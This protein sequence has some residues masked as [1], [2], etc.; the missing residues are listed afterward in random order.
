MLPT[1]P[2]PSPLLALALAVSAAGA[3]AL[4][5]GPPGAAAAAGLAAVA[6]L[7]LAAASAPGTADAAAW[8]ETRSVEAGP[9]P[10]AVPEPP[11]PDGG[12][13]AGPLPD[14]AVRALGEAAAALRAPLASARSELSML[15]DRLEAAGDLPAAR[16]LASAREGLAAAERHA[17]VARALAGSLGRGPHALDLGVLA[18][19]V[20]DSC[21]PAVAAN[22]TRLTVRLGCPLP[23]LGHPRALEAA[24]RVLLD[25]GLAACNAIAR[26]GRLEVRATRDGAY[27]RVEIADS[28]RTSR[29]SPGPGA[30][31]SGP[32]D[33]ARALLR[34]HGGDLLLMG[35]DPV[36]EGALRVLTV[37]LAAEQPAAARAEWGVEAA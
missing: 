21:A 7:A 32:L 36:L 26:P 11:P 34:A 1:L 8:R 30:P 15:A 28:R 23:V 24:L 16:L 19:R 17:A 20:G 27:A 9:G 18:S 6:T 29:L 31:P 25:D 4:V 35:R 12:R 10:E 14:P 22:G 33:L 3:G 37:P 13:T 2:A 5:A